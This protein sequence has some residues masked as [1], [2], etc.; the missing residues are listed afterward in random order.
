MQDIDYLLLELRQ[1]E[2]ELFNTNTRKSGRVEELLAVNFVEFGSSGQVYDKDQIVSA[3]KTETPSKITGHEFQVT[4]LAPDTALLTY[5][6][7]H[8]AVPAIYSLRSSVWQRVNR[9]WRIVFHQATRSTELSKL[10][11]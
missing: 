9:R 10:G 3:L 8:H 4:R 6:A 2:E 1:L 7:C 5:R 11:F